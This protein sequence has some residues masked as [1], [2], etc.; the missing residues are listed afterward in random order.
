MRASRKPSFCNNKNSSSKSQRLTWQPI[1]SEKFISTLTHA[2][3]NPLNTI[4]GAATLL[5]PKFSKDKHLKRL[6]GIIISEVD[7]I[8][9]MIDDLQSL[10]QEALYPREFCDF[11]S[12][13]DDVLFSPKEKVVSTNITVK[14]DFDR[15][16]PSISVNYVEMRKAL[17]CVVS[18]ALEGME[19]KGTLTVS[20]RSLKSSDFVVIRVHARGHD[21]R[22]QN[23]KEL[24]QPTFAT[25]QKGYGLG[26]SS[27]FQ[28]IMKHGGTIKTGSQPG[29]GTMLSMR[30][31]ICANGVP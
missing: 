18:S 31:P 11:H 1:Q 22:S 21:T 4:K 14:T 20:T 9:R 27:V 15:R 24:F 13:I 16:I 19:G 25:G 12:L 7:R 29:E 30:L 26:M 23:V 5:G 6:P 3:R 2:L 10:A 8:D 17:S 28:T